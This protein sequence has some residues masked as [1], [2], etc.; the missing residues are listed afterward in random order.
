LKVELINDHPAGTGIYS[1]TMNIYHNLMEHGIKVELHD[2]G[3]RGT[4][5]SLL[6]PR[7]L[8]FTG[9]IVHLS[10][11]NLG[12][13]ASRTD[14][15]ITVHDLYYLH[16][17][18]NSRAW[19]WYCRR[20]YE[21]LHNAGLIVAN[22]HST[23]SELKR[24]MGID[25]VRV[26]YPS[27]G[28]EFKSEGGRLNLWPNK[29]VLLHVGYD[30][31]NKNIITILQALKDLPEDYVLVRVGRDSSRT[32]KAIREM[33]LERRYRNVK[34]ESSEELASVYR[35]SHAMV[36]PSLYE[37]FGIPVIEAMACGLPVISSDRYGLKESAV[38]ALII[39]PLEPKAIADAVLSLEDSYEK[40][41]IEG[42][43]N[44][45]RFSRENQFKQL[46]SAYSVEPQVIP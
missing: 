34:A 8:R 6:L 1:Y 36:F 25:R 39:D 2:Y 16:Y 20:N 45:A 14:A 18:S 38:G 27:I 35:S 28:R 37:G 11:P 9:D 44:A 26:V 12:F 46:M 13:I 30:M 41:R 7:I 23:E 42:M 15:I 17:L 19:S 21:S 32:L 4:L 31:P 43:K 22:S 10:N 40:I 3:N 33:G 5:L 29:K 24:E